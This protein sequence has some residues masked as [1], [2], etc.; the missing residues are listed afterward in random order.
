VAVWRAG[1]NR[2]LWVVGFIISV[3]FS[4]LAALGINLQKQ[5]LRMHENDVPKTPPLQQRVPC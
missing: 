2:A 5:S 3:V 1:P 4:F